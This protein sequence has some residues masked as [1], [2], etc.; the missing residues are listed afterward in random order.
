VIV[1]SPTNVISMQKNGEL[2]C[3][4]IADRYDKSL[5]GLKLDKPALVRTDATCNPACHS[6]VWLDLGNRKRRKPLTFRATESQ[7][8][9]KEMTDL[10]KD[11]HLQDDRRHCPGPIEPRLHL[12]SDALIIRSKIK[13]VA[14]NGWL[15]IRS[16]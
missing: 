8:A 1:A 14:T 2:G 6:D 12:L 5:E 7:F 11:P 15:V 3:I 4:S 9:A 10:P 16:C 13:Q